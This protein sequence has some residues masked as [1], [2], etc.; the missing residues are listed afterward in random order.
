MEPANSLDPQSN[1]VANYGSRR[2][3]GLLRIVAIVLV[4]FLL[5]L[6]FYWILS[7]MA[8]KDRQKQSVL[9]GLNNTKVSQEKIDQLAAALTNQT[10]ATT[11]ASTT[12]VN[13]VILNQP[14]ATVSKNPT[15]LAAEKIDRPHLGNTQAGLVIVEFADFA[16]PIC[17]RE[18]YNIREFASQHQNDILYIYR[19]FPIEG[20]L[21]S[22]L[23]KMALCAQ[24][25]NK[26]WQLHDRFFMSQAQLTTLENA[27]SLAKQVG[28]NMNLLN[29]C[30]TADRYQALVAEDLKDAGTLGVQG[31]PTFFINGKKLEGAVTLENWQALF[32][33]YK[34]ALGG[35]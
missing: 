12:P 4:V 24:E 22:N 16:C 34:E 2:P 1:P 29:S 14:N 15:R 19:F 11:T 27:I 31:T 21:S 23:Y 7:V 32:D 10:V 28:L 18:F 5:L 17:Q 26:F 25:Q 35:G 6:F 20:E 8:E 30:M 13:P 9:N 3:G 33:K